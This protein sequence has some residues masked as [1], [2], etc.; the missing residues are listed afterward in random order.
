MD[1]FPKVAR[2]LQSHRISN[3]KAVSQCLAKSSLMVQHLPGVV[4]YMVQTVCCLNVY[5]AVMIDP[6]L[7]T[8]LPLQEVQLI[9]TCL[10]CQRH[11][12]ITQLSTAKM[13]VQ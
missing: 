10:L 8:I 13:S 9:C 11:I 1:G 5:K 7:R 2:P 12:A 4:R 6:K 3:M